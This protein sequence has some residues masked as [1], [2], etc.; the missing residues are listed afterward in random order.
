LS[1]VIDVKSVGHLDEGHPKVDRYQFDIR[2]ILIKDKA[3]HSSLGESIRKG[4]K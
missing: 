2:L 1:G 3:V 4:I